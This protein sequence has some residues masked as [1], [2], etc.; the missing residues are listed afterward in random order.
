MSLTSRLYTSKEKKS[1]PIFS[2]FN[3]PEALSEEEEEDE[4]PEVLDSED[5]RSSSEEDTP[6]N[7]PD[8]EPLGATARPPS[9]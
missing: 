8:P 6:F 2:D 9:S 4:P 7:H 1:Q 3:T 5:P